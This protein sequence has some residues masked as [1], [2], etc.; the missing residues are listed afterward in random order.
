MQPGAN[1]TIMSV[2]TT[3]K[4]VI[5]FDQ[6]EGSGEDVILSKAWAVLAE[7]ISEQKKPAD[8][9]AA[10]SPGVSSTDEAAPDSPGNATW[11]AG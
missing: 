5:E 6:E 11:F 10:S 2:G 8:E 3:A 1:V 7:R 4:V 9:G